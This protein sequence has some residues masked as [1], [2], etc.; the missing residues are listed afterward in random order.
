MSVPCFFCFS[1]L[2]NPLLKYSWNCTKIYRDFLVHVL[3]AGADRILVDQVDWID[4]GCGVVFYSIR[5]LAWHR[6]W[7]QNKHAGYL[8]LR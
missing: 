5:M 7:Q 1:I 8:A 6:K 3:R 2:E 4:C